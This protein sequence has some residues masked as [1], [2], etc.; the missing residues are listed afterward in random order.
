MYRRICIMILVLAHGIGA[1]AQLTI[2]DVTLAPRMSLGDQE[3]V[4]NGGG[5]RKRFFL[6]IYVSGLYVSEASSDAKV[7]VGANKAMSIQLHI[8][9]DLITSGQLISSIEEGFDKSTGGNQEQFR[10]EIDALTN[11]FNE[12]FG[13]GDIFD[14][15]FTPEAGVG[16]YKNGTMT[17]TVGDLEFKKALWGIW[18][19]DNPV[20]QKLKQGMLGL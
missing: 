1:N 8:V 20:D 10:R 14:I 3:F 6:N 12:K 18:L 4:L 16:V 9:S 13:K 15:V 11:P 19:G 7:I 2:E 5:L 17:T